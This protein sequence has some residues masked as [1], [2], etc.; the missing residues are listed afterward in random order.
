MLPVLTG[1]ISVYFVEF[2]GLSKGKVRLFRSKKT[3]KVFVKNLDG[4]FRHACSSTRSSSPPKILG[5]CGPMRSPGASY[6]HLDAWPF[7]CRLLL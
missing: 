1:I 5:C 3:G 7:L 6:K 4:C 2:W